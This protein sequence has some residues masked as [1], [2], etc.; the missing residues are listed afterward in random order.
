MKFGIIGCGKMGSAILQGVENN[1]FKKEDIS[2]FDVSEAC[3]QNMQSN[4][5]KTAKTTEEVFT[6]SDIILL[7][8]KPQELT[9]V[10][11]KLENIDNKGK[12]IISI[13]A[14]IPISLIERFLKGVAIARIMPNTCASINMAASTVCFNSLCNEE[15][16]NLVLSI[17]NAI[18]TTVVVD[19]SQMNDT[20]P[21]NGSFNA[22]AYYYIKAFIESSKK[23]GIDEE[24][25]KQ[26]LVQ[27]T[28]GSMNMILKS[29]KSIDT[30]IEEV[31]SKGGTTLAG[32]QALYDND[33]MGVVDKCACACADRSRELGK[34][35]D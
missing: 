35:F 8:I 14:G 33:L 13:C 11:S 32:L 30:L 2:I 4:G 28:I 16:R 21:L 24:I 31:C 19:E 26:L 10:L 6:N 18:G 5:Y 12:L 23:R 9:N 1:I 3:T 27:T 15:N 7:S 29:G 34:Q 20:L 25:A 22:F 17:F